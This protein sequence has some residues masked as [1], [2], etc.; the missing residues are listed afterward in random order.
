M[1]FIYMILIMVVNDVELI[2]SKDV[3]YTFKSHI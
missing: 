1:I 3:V 2:I